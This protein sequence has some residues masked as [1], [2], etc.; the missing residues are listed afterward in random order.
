MNAHLIYA[1]LGLGLI[2]GVLW[3]GIAPTPVATPST[4][5]VFAEELSVKHTVPS[6][7]DTLALP[8]SSMQSRFVTGIE[9]I[10]ASLQG[11]AVDGSFEVD[12]QGHLNVTKGVRQVFDYFLSAE[13]E[14]DQATLVQRIRAYIHAQLKAPA[15][16]E[17]ERLLDQYL[18]YLAALKQMQPIQGDPTHQLDQVRAQKQQI[19][20]IRAKTF[21]RPTVEVFFA[22]EDAYDDYTLARLDVLN[23]AALTLQQKSLKIKEIT[24]KLAPDMQEDVRVINQ[25]Q[26]LTALTQEWKAKGGDAAQ[27]RQIREQ[28][29]GQAAADRLEQLDRDNAVWDQRTQSYLQQRDALIKQTNLAQIDQQKAIAQLRQ[30]LFD[31]QEQVRIDALETIHDQGLTIPA[32]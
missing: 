23:N 21:D 6:L 14:E 19:A 4:S 30:R 17:A 25:Y 20:D 2:V 10:P 8:V 5:A 27:L 7:S 12:A 3:V 9:H 1:T 22:D 15:D 29:V 18:A 32:S 24:A 16:R 26:D 13:G 11:T 28:V 31:G